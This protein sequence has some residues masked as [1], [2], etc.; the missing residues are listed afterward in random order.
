MLYE[1]LKEALSLA[2]ALQKEAES[3]GLTLK[4]S[5][6]WVALFDILVVEE[7]LR[8][9]SRKLFMDGHY[10]RAVEEAYKCLNNQVR[11]KAGAGRSLDGSAL[12]K[13]VFSLNNPR[14]KLNNLQSESER[15]EQ[16]G[17]MEIFS[18]C[19]IGIRNPRVHEHSYTDT[20]QRAIE[21]LTFANYL[22]RVVMEAQV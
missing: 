15:D 8:R 10:A 13:N 17:H 21:L 1:E 20:P 11:R 2:S 7:P 5:L 3:R 9:V 19:M 18:G 6:D 4:V 12:M 16:L 22:F 14:L